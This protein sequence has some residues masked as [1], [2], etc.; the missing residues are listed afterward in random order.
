MRFFST[1]LF[2]ALLSLSGAAAVS[3]ADLKTAIFAGGCF[4]CVESDYEMV[5]GVV[6]AVSGYTGGTAVNAN[7]KKVSKGRTKHLEAVQITYDANIVSYETLVDIFW[8]TIDP[9][10]AG[11]QFCD[12]GDS[13]RTA[14]F[15]L[16][17]TQLQAAKA[18]KAAAQTALGQTIVTAVIPASAFYPAEEY[19]QDYY[20]SK[21]KVLTRFGRI[22][23]KDAYKRYRKACGRDARVKELWGN[24]AFVVAGS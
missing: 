10:D 9:T 20:K 18:A 12:R 2:A 24:R 5:P 1:L 14:V 23:K 13:Y 6:S 4:W 15:A 22:T 11:G 16:D 19:H 7:Y 8:R 17:D 3:A 21:K